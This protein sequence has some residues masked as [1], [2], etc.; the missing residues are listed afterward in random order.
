MMF[1][2]PAQNVS[3]ARNSVRQAVR[4]LACGATLIEMERALQV[5]VDHKNEW[6]AT[7]W[8]EVIAEKIAEDAE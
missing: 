6:L 2:T 4:N 8:R 1:E 7:C 5:A 3:C